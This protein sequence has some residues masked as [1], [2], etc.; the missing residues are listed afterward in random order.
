M[1]WAPRRMPRRLRSLI[2][3]PSGPIGGAVQR[4]PPSLVGVGVLSGPTPRRRV[5]FPPPGP[6]AEGQAGLP[7]WPGSRSGSC[8]VS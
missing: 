8:P 3:S 4:R 5:L 7:P 6:L 1:D 2:R